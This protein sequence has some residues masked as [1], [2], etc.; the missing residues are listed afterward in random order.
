MLV[1]YRQI[2]HG[3]QLTDLQLEVLK[4]Y[5]QANQLLVDCLNSDCRYSSVIRADIEA[6]LFKSEVG[7][8]KCEV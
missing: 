6:T 2:G 7:S 3:W 8:V 5:Y 4:Q 1:E